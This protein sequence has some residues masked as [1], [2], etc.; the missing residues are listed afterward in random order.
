LSDRADDRHIDSKEE[1][2]RTSIA[3]SVL[4]LGLLVVPGAMAN[5]SYS[6]PAGDSGAAPDITSVTAS[7]DDA[8]FVSLAATTNQPVL[9]PDATFWGYIDA[10]RDAATGMPINGLGVDEMFLGDGTGGLLA[11]IDG[12]SLQIAF[13]STLTTSYANGVFTARFNRSELGTTDRFAFALESELDDANGDTIA[14]DDAP[15]GPPGY[16]YSFVPLA[17]TV[18]PAASAPKLPVAG[19]RFVVSAAVTRSDTQP[20]AAGGVTCA[21]RAGKVVLRPAASVGGGSARCA[22]KVPKSAKGKLLRGSLTVSAEDS[23]P[24]TRA[25]S[26]RIR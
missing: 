18:G 22:M 17:L 10:D 21:A 2:M 20:F 9:S 23:A 14:S 16:E 4:A 12:D 3:L 8:G 25:F 6:D 7:H 5:R 24:V 15:D 1:V 26:Y 19:K 11:H 13:G